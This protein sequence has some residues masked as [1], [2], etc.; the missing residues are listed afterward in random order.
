MSVTRDVEPD[1]PSDVVTSAPIPSTEE[2]NAALDDRR[3][4][5]T[6]TTRDAVTMKLHKSFRPV[7]TGNVMKVIIISDLQ[8][9]TVLFDPATA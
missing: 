3:E 7:T 8:W 6:I 1:L 9:L 5:V 2:R 4:D